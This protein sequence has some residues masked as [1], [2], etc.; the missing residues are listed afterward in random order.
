MQDTDKVATATIRDL[1]AEFDVTPR[2]L[3]H[4]E[5]I[6][7]LSP[8]RDGQKRL[9]SMRDRARLKL[10]LR[11]KRFGFRLEELRELLDLYDVDPT[12][13]TQLTRT[14]EI[15]RGKLDMLTA[16]RRELDA[17]IAD[18]KDQLALVD[19]MIEAR[20]REDAPAKDAAGA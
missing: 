13:L 7:L 9:Y 2:T 8:Q 15:A 12:Q 5:A 17:A 6:G 18:L 10:I 16:Q 11:G 1:C 20:R 3:R 14:V 4:Y 19:D